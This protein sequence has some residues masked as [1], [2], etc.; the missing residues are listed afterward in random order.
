[1]F[2]PL[3]LILINYVCAL[4]FSSESIRSP[5]HPPGTLTQTGMS[6]P[7]GEFVVVKK[8]ES[9]GKGFT[10]VDKTLVQKTE[11]NL[12]YAGFLL[13]LFIVQEAIWDVRLL[14]AVHCLPA[15][16]SLMLPLL[17]L[18]EKDNFVIS[19][20]VIVN[21]AAGSVPAGYEFVYNTVQGMFACFVTRL[22]LRFSR[23]SEE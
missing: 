20:I 16:R 6:Q 12:R 8:G 18:T 19:D 10:V 13:C 11:V 23:Q 22:I 2:C 14:A 4:K 9:L 1:M 21:C 17:L 7:I 3:S 15:C 5:A